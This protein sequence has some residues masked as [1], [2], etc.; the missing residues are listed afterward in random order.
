MGEVS[1]AGLKA[2][3]LRNAAAVLEVDL[4]ELMAKARLLTRYRPQS[5]FPT[6]ARD[7]N[8]IVDERVRWA[9]LAA[10]ARSAAGPTLERIEYLDTYRD[11]GKD[12]PGKK[13]LLFSLTLR[14]D[15]RTLTGQEADTVRDAVVAACTERHAAKLLS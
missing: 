12:G 7:I 10:T 14:P 13:R 2:F 9:D 11:A 4:S 6:M 15:D 1:T 5:P 3:G 8:L